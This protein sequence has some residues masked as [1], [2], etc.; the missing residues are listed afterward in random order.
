[1]LRNTAAR[2][3]EQ[4]LI[5]TALFVHYVL[6]EVEEPCNYLAVLWSKISVC[7][8]SRNNSLVTPR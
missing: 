1:M 3:D 5:G 6:H 7:Q 2:H 8:K 4:L